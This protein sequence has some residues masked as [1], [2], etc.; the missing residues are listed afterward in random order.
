MALF[1]QVTKSS[2]KIFSSL[3]RCSNVSHNILYHWPSMRLRWISH[4]K[5]AVPRKMIGTNPR[6][7]TV[8]NKTYALFADNFRFTLLG[9]GSDAELFMSLVRWIKFMKISVSESTR[10]ACFNLEWL[11][12]PFFLPIPA[13]NFAF[14]ATLERLWFRC[15]TF[16]VANLKHKLL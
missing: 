15:P 9:P 16:H 12:Q 6:L 1:T 10:N 4:F 7:V 8:T 14:G 5:F 2:P 13:G 3:V 11:M